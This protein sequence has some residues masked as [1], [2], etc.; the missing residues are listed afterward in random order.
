MAYDRYHN[1]Y[2]GYDDE[3]NDYI[4]RRGRRDEGY[5]DHNHMPYHQQL[6]KRL[7]P[8]GNYPKGTLAFKDGKGFETHSLNLLDP[9]SERHIALLDR[10]RKRRRANPDTPAHDIVSRA[11]FPPPGVEA[12]LQHI[13]DGPRGG[14]WVLAKGKEEVVACLV[15]ELE[16]TQK[17]GLKQA[18]GE[19]E[20]DLSGWQVI[21]T[22]TGVWSGSVFLL[23]PCGDGGPET[24]EE[25]APEKGTAGAGIGKAKGKGQ[26]GLISKFRHTFD[27]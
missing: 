15:D 12:C 7:P 17:K 10:S 25:K 2:S 18:G 27:F 1:G 21:G 4:N 11:A 16:Q 9:R 5:D 14:I 8:P 20:S 22:G 26:G 23:H 13:S 19:R 3:Y 6:D 24:M